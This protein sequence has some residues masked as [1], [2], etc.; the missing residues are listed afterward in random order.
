MPIVAYCIK[1]VKAKGDTH[2]AETTAS[3]LSQL[4]HLHT[5]VT[6]PRYDTTSAEKKKAAYGNYHIKACQNKTVRV[7]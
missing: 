1:A 7:C 5:H 3:I 2:T 6:A 4:N